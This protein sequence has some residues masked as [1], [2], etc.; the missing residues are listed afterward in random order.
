M[1]NVGSILG[2]IDIAS[3]V[4]RL[5]SALQHLDGIESLQQ[6]VA[7]LNS[8]LTELDQY[9]LTD[10][11]ALIGD[12]SPVKQTILDCGKTMEQIMAVLGKYEDIKTANTFQR[13]NGS[14][15]I[16][17][18]GQSNLFGLFFERLKQ[19]RA[20]EMVPYQQHI[21]PI[22]ELGHGLFQS[23]REFE[24]KLILSQEVCTSLKR[25]YGAR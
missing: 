3:I 19:C 24:V 23:P 12:I 1:E 8:T 2:V 20:V 5:C 4:Y 9:G 18:R 13:K 21:L 14:L 16:Y 11:E 25:S 15:D 7:S 22:Q 10:R 17:N 6:E